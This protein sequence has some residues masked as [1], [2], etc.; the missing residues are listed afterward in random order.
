MAL[1]EWHRRVALRQLSLA[2]VR[3]HVLRHL[4]FLSLVHTKA[5]ASSSHVGIVIWR[6]LGYFLHDLLVELY[7]I[8]PVIF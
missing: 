1:Y 7:G 4:P 3:T 6:Y 8:V 2:L 5:E